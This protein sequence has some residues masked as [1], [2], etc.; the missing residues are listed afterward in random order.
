MSGFVH[1]VRAEV[2]KLLR[3]RRTYVLAGLWWGLLPAL[4]LLVGRVVQTTLGGSFANEAGGID[5]V[6]Q[7]LAS[8]FG[9]ARIGLVGPAYVTPS[10][11]L[12]VV[13]LL[14]ALL[15]G[16]ERGHN[17]WKTVLVAQP[18]RLAVMAGKVVVAMLALGGL[19]AGAAVAA[20]VFGAI[21]TLF[22]PTTWAGEWGELLSLYALQW[23][24]SLALVLFTFLLVFVFKNMVLGIVTA[25]FLPGL[26]EGIYTLYRATVGF[27]PVNRINVFFQAIELQQRLEAIPRY[28]FTSNAYAPARSPVSDLLRGLSAGGADIPPDALGQLLGTGITLQHAAT[29]MAGYALVFGA[30]LL[31]RFVRHDVE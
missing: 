30:V 16:E 12:I 28:F 22:L 18:Q 27:E 9:L 17:M 11:Y 5:V 14:A 20:L 1:V 7:A 13:A 4:G 26:L 21:G 6:V 2:F 23:A 29:V 8:P 25:F 24:V 10:F 3:K 15:I 19:M 31:W